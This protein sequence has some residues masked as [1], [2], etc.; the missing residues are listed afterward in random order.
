VIG[1]DVVSARLQRG[2][3]GAVHF[4]PID[5]H[6]S[7]IVVIEIERHEIEVAHLGR[8]RIFERPYDFDDILHRRLFHA[9]FEPRF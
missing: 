2:E 4:G 7:R 5:S 6:V 1:D 3:H 8:K 9:L